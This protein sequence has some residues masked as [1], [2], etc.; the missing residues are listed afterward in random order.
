MK[1]ILQCVQGNSFFFTMDLI[2][3]PPEGFIDRRPLYWTYPPQQPETEGA[4]SL[5]PS[6]LRDSDGRWCVTMSCRVCSIP[7]ILWSGVFH[8]PPKGNSLVQGCRHSLYKS[9]PLSP[10][11]R[12]WGSFSRALFLARLPLIVSMFLSHSFL[13]PF[14]AKRVLDHGS[15]RIRTQRNLD[16]ETK[17]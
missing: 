3:F 7:R 16:P 14:L 4:W 12:E 17:C 2:F 5:S 9:A 1:S 13:L 6:S 10:H 8:T 11:C 15:L